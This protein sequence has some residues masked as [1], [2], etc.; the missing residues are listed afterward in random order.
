MVSQLGLGAENE[1]ANLSTVDDRSKER[2]RRERM[3]MH[4]ALKEKNK[5]PREDERVAM[6]GRTAERR[7]DKKM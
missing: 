5:R 7:R 6:I 3:S 4:I 2:E 1:G